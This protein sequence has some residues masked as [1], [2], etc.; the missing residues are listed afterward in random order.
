MCS[1]H[2]STARLQ[3][4]HLKWW[5]G[6]WALRYWNIAVQM[7]RERSFK[8]TLERI[9]FIKLRFKSL[10]V[11][12]FTQESVIFALYTLWF[13]NDLDNFAFTHLYRKS[14]MFPWYLLWS[15]FYLSWAIFSLNSSQ[16]CGREQLCRQ[17]RKNVKA[18]KRQGTNYKVTNETVWHA[19]VFTKRA[20][21]CFLP[22]CL[23]YVENYRGRKNKHLLA[24][25]T[26]K[27]TII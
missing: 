5:C 7:E 19:A 4:L 9:F 2:W 17:N 14:T 18:D 13:W 8:A 16:L 6:L 21:T 10:W 25:F 11:L 22:Q 24:V 1:K 12:W 20:A 3:S 27:F 15:F 26:E 23:L